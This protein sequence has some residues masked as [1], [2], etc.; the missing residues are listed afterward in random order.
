MKR[1]GID[2]DELKKENPR[3][4]YCSITGY[5]STGSYSKRAGHDINYMALAGM[6]GLSGKSGTV[7]PLP[8]FQGADASGAMQ[9]VIGI[10]SAIIERFTTNVGQFVD[11]SLTE[12]AM[13]LAVPSLAA[14]IASKDMERGTSLLDGGIINYN[15]YETKDQKYITVGALEDHFW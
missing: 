13:A 14:Q 4:I 10:Q 1:L 15:I 5:G 6:I 12:A 3:L 9:A 11:V 7:P 8:G 2:Y